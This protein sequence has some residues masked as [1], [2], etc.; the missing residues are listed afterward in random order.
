MSEYVHLIGNL[1]LVGI[2]IN[3]EA[4]NLPLE[5]KV[6]VLRESR[7]QS[8][9]ELIDELEARDSLYWNQEDIEERGRKLAE[10]SY[11]EIWT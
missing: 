9:V 7:I 6:G 4:S 1:L 5:Q 8:T 2:P 3:S 10:L 11:E